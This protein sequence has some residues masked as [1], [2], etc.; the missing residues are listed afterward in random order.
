MSRLLLIPTETESRELFDR[1]RR[2]SVPGH[3]EHPVFSGWRIEHCGLG[4]VAAAARSAA[5][6]E[7]LRPS[8]IVLAGIAGALDETLAIGTAYEFRRVWVDGLGAGSAD[9]GSESNYLSI[10]EMGWAQ[11]PGDEMTPRVGDVISLDM[12]PPD[13]GR[14]AFDKFASLG[15][16]TVCAASGDRRQ[17]ERRRQY[18]PE[19]AAEDMEGF[20]VAMSCVLAGVPLRIIRGISNVAG[21]RNAS[22]W[23]IGDALTAVAER[24]GTLLA[25]DRGGTTGLDTPTK[26]G[27]E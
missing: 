24:L 23:K 26:K 10:G 11:W 17:S 15:L 18:Y 19:A 3:A 13:D 6:I 25:E 20:G 22:Q 21:N 2:I 14:N 9:R 4:V 8:R 1:C 27:T 5:L 7:R 12:P 16:L